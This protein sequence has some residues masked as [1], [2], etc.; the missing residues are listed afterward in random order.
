[1]K[2]Y[3]SQNFQTTIDDGLN[4]GEMFKLIYTKKTLML[5]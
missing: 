3:L 5:M 4:K 2:L 1:M